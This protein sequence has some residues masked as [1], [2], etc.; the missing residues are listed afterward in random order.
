MAAAIRVD[1][2]AR[3]CPISLVRQAQRFHPA[4]RGHVHAATVPR[5]AASCAL[6][7]LANAASNHVPS[8]TA[9]ERSDDATLPALGLAAAR[10][11]VADVGVGAGPPK[12]HTA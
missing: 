12:D 1:M 9:Q 5:A 11:L 10:H 4:R 7:P 2:I 6:R 3:S 8:P